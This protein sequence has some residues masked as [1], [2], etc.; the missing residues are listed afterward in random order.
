MTSSSA[1]RTK[2]AHEE[3]RKPRMRGKRGK[4]KRGGVLVKQ[5][6]WQDKKL[7]APIIAGNVVPLFVHEQREHFVAYLPAQAVS[8]SLS[9][10][11]A[12][13]DAALPPCAQLDDVTLA[14]KKVAMDEEVA[15]SNAQVSGA[16]L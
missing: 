7:V 16:K 2:S 9:T 12:S 8:L 4:G 13:V 14:K 15:A 6:Y 3:Q 11:V 10:R 1:D 5:R